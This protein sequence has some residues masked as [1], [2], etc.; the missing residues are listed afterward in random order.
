MGTLIPPSP[1][2]FRQQR[3]EYSRTLKIVLSVTIVLVGLASAPARS[4]PGGGTV[5]KTAYNA[6]LKRTIVVDAHGRTVYLFTSDTKG[7]A[8]CA[9][10]DPACPSIWP[11]VA[12]RGTPVAGNGVLGRLLGVTKGAHGV[13]QVTY[14]HHPLYYFHGGQGFV[15]DSKAGDANGEGFFNVWYVLSP[16]GNPIKLR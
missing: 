14:N 6:K 5:I 10:A 15:G 13:A 2:D 3:A 9:Q 1:L 11:A 7:K 16:K 12:A 4:A 8:T